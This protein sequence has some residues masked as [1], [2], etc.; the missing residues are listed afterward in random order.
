METERS[1]H[2]PFLEKIR[3]SIANNAIADETSPADR[4][5]E[6]P[7]PTHCHGPLC[8]TFVCQIGT[9]PIGDSVSIKL[10]VILRYDQFQSVSSVEEI[11]GELI[12]MFVDHRNWI[13]RNRLLLFQMRVHKCEK[14]HGILQGFSQINIPSFNER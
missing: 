2:R 14:Y 4:A 8:K 11:S 10:K 12:S 7:L 6:S 9:L 5:L 1:D 13:V 3:S